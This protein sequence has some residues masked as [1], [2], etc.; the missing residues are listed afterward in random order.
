MKISARAFEVMMV[1]KELEVRHCLGP[2]TLRLT[3]QKQ[4]Q[5][6]DAEMRLIK[7]MEI[8]KGE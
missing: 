6:N 2:Y 3:K 7:D 8:N 5:Q 1:R 4:S